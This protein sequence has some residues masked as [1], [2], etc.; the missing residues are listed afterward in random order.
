[1]R[2]R[3]LQQLFAGGAPH[4]LDDSR[5]WQLDTTSLPAQ[6]VVRLLAGVTDTRPRVSRALDLLRGWDGNVRADSAAAA[7]FEVWFTN[8]LRPAV[9]RAV[10]SPEAAARIGAGDASRVLQVM[11][12]HG[13]WLPR[14]RR[15]RIVLES[16]ADAL[17]EIEKRLGP[18]PTHWRWGRL[19]EAVFEHPL[20]ARVDAETRRRLTV[21]SWPLGGS[22]A[23]PMAASY[24]PNDYQL[25]SGASFRMVVDVGHWDASVAINT[26]GQSG[27]PASPHYRD[28]APL[29]AEGRYFPLVYSR[30]AVET[31]MRTRI[32]LKP[33]QE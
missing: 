14:E 13:G 4:R 24:R 29:W 27:D 17:T 16:L 26:P 2:A 12:G 15:D 19:H 20:A 18:D 32:E 7:V 9:V 33:P 11:E 21:G 22:S 10:L 25:T 28:L 1:M 23:T 3:R 8:H 5:A 31:S 30:D 6:R